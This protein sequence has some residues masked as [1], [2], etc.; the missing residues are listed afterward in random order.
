M[1]APYFAKPFGNSGHT[2]VEAA[3]RIASG[4][5][6]KERLLI[7]LL[8]LEGRRPSEIA[9]I[10]HRD[11]DTV[12]SWLHRW[13]DSGF[14]GLHDRPYPGRPPVLT[15]G[16]QDQ[17]IKRVPDEVHS[18]KR[19][20]C[21]HIAD[22]IQYVFGKTADEDTVRRMMHRHRCSRRK[23]GTKDHRADPELQKDFQENIRNRMENE[24]ET[25]FFFT[26][27]CI[28]QLSASAVSTWGLKGNRPVF[29]TNLSRE[30]IIETG[31]VDPLTGDNFHMSV[32]FT[33][34][35]SFSVSVRESAKAFP[36]D[37][38]VLIHDGASWHNI[39]PPEKRVEPVKL[40]PYSPELNP[41]E[42]LWQ[43]I[44]NNFTHNRFFDTVDELEQALINCLKSE[45]DLRQAICS[46][47]TMT[48]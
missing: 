2:A 41:I 18:G 9:L 25:R 48:Y 26:D 8:S 3:Y 34:K 4:G 31:A 10:I 1:S 30:K 12:L 19:L 44:R 23:P 13:N 6:L 47:C 32:P 35:E 16:E 39:V 21:R 33:T 43:W 22:H 45:T 7:V 40:P 14:E 42:H 46:V 38:I 11:A 17:I 20:T 37:K 27:E 5:R 36:D 24:P 29:K 15:A 28:F